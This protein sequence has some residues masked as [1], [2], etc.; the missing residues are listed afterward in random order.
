MNTNRLYKIADYVNDKEDTIYTVRFMQRFSEYLIKECIHALWTPECNDSK[1]VADEFL[2]NADRIKKY[3]DIQNDDGSVVIDVPM[4]EMEKLNSII[5]KTYLTD[6]AVETWWNKRNPA[7]SNM[8]P[9]SVYDM[10]STSQNKINEYI[11]NELWKEIASGM[12]EQ[13]IDDM[14][15]NELREE[16]KNDPEGFKARQTKW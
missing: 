8:S 16:M 13:E 6:D 12:T 15:A 10:G 14:I 5:K 11:K 1:D 7:F 3:F 9:R 2:R 4:S